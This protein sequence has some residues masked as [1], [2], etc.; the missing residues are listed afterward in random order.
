MCIVVLLVIYSNCQITYFFFYLF[1]PYSGFGGKGPLARNDINNSSEWLFKRCI[2][3][4]YYYY[5]PWRQPAVLPTIMSISSSNPMFYHLL[6]LSR[7]D[8]SNKRSNIGF[9]EEITQVESIDFIF[10]HLF[11]SSGV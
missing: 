4:L 9:S 6:E 8:N 3:V 10:M 5:S 7:R 1:Y 2:T 11:W